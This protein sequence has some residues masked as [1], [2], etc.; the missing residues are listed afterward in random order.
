MPAAICGNSRVNEQ[1]GILLQLRHWSLVRE[2]ADGPL[3]LLRDLDL[4]LH[5]GELLGLLGEN[6]SGK[7]S[8][9]RWLAGEDSPLRTMAALVFQD[10]DEQLVTA[11]VAEELTLGRPGL[12]PQPLLEEFGLAGMADRDPRLLSAGEKQ[13]LVLAVALAGRPQVLLCDEP[14]S[15]QDSG[16]SAWL[17]DRLQAWR[18]AAG[19][20]LVLATQRRA[21]AE[22]CDR[23]LLLQDGRAAACGEP[24]QVLACP[25]ARELLSPLV[26]E[27]QAPAATSPGGSAPSAVPVAEWRDVGHRFPTGGGFRGVNRVLQAG[28]RLGITGPNGCGK[29][30]LLAMAAGLLAPAEGRCHLDGHPLCSRGAPDLDHRVAL[31]APQFPEYFFTRA[32]VGAEIALDPALVG[33]AG[34]VLAAAGLPGAWTGRNPHDLSS[35]ERRRLAVA[36]TVLSGRRLLLL[37]EPTAGLDLEGRRRLL[38]LLR[39]IP[40]PAALVVASH[41]AEFLTA[42]GCS[43]YELGPTGLVWDAL[44]GGDRPLAPAAPLG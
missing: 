4:T 27:A 6:G 35:G 21:E 32:T 42:C 12:E 38:A 33:R 9:L 25:A 3:P 24:T 1:G 40:P 39:R 43:T 29:S 30:L 28:D 8:L 36:L 22:L 10:P 16:Q 7:T 19:G 15:L 18:R 14:T 11:R 23:L 37:D 20:T 17:L 31:L 26:P 5:R 13:R 44:R 34:E 41:D 2:T